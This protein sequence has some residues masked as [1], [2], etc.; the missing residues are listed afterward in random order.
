[1][2][3]A[4]SLLASHQKWG[5]QRYITWE[6]KWFILQ[7]LQLLDMLHVYIGRVASLLT[8]FSLHSQRV[9]ALTLYG[10]CS[11][12]QHHSGACH[13]SLMHHLIFLSFSSK[14]WPFTVAEYSFQ[15]VSIFQPSRLN[16]PGYNIDVLGWKRKGVVIAPLLTFCILE[17]IWANS[18]PPKIGKKDTSSSLEVLNERM[19]KNHSHLSCRA[20]LETM[21]C[22]AHW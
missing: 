3:S 6:K 19:E 8:F 11:V 20:D 9:C 7:W 22:E 15:T 10:A 4:G 2:H 17:I 21:L 1:M 16:I 5:S 18:F 13:A 14:L 12:L